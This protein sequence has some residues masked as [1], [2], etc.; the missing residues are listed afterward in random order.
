MAPC[1]PPTP[2]SETFPEPNRPLPWS[3]QYWLYYAHNYTFKIN[4]HTNDYY[5]YV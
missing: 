1:R 3:A 5:V 4:I 2:V